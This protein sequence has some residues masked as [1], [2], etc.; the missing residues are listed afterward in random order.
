MLPHGFM[1]ARIAVYGL[2]PSKVIVVYFVP[3]A[4]F[5]VHPFNKAQVPVVPRSK[6][7]IVLMRNNNCL[8]TLLIF[9]RLKI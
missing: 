2:N 9:T 1:S 5:H 7:A 4:V 8:N 3:M 6:S